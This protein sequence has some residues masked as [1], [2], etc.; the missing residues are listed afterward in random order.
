MLKRETTKQNSWGEAMPELKELY[1]GMIENMGVPDLEIPFTA[2][3]FYRGKEE[4]PETVLKHR[5]ADISL[6]SC[7]AAKQA[8]LGDMICLTREN[9]G[10]VAAAITFGL[11]AK[12]EKQPLA[13]SRVY[14]DIMK[15]QAAEGDDFTPPTPSEFTEGVVYACKDAGRDDFALF[16][17]EDSGRYRD[18]ETAKRAVKEMSAIEPADTK[19]VFF[20][21]AEF[22]EIAVT[23]DVIVMSVRP[24]E[25]TRLVQAYQSTRERGSTPAWGGSGW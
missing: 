12:D 3:E 15:K 14:T 11:V 5:P 16:G 19:A 23:P 25:L 20:Y 8:A 24:V 4:V 17:K 7:Q 1:D 2:V 18:A 22:D 9:I 21:P 10:C 13:G 6:T